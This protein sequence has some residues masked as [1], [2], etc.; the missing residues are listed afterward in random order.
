[1]S[2]YND[3]CIIYNNFNYLKQAHHQVI[4]NIGTFHS[5]TTGK[6]V[7]RSYIPEG[8]LQQWMFYKD[9][10]L[11]IQ[12]VAKAPGNSYNAIQAQISTSLIIDA[13]HCAYPAAVDTVF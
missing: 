12:D 2:S 9:V 1:M 3:V 4:S 6:I 10:P 8:G 7:Y 5:Y 13:I 11:H